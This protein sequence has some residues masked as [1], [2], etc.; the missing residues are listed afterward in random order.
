MAKNQGGRGNRPDD[1]R[2]GRSPEDMIPPDVDPNPV[3]PVI[4]ESALDEP[5]DA[6]PRAQ[7]HVT[8]D[9]EFQPRMIGDGQYVRD[10]SDL[11]TQGREHDERELSDAERLE[12]F[13]L[14]TFQNQLPILP[15]ELF[16]TDHLCW[17]TTSNTRDPIQGRIRLGYKLIQINELPGWEHSVINTGLY[18]GCVGIN[19]MVAAKLPLRLFEMYMTEAHHNQPLAEEGKLRATLDVIKESARGGLKGPVIEEESTAQLGTRTRRPR[20][21]GIPTRS[22]R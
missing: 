7:I 4:D 19:E 22:T 8:G 5:L 2:I 9:E 12:L 20:F 21:E 1:E 15:Q 16:P 11:A 18:S 14:T 6:Q 17:L 10:D 13:R 3:L